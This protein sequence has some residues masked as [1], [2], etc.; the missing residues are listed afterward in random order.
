[1]KQRI[2]SL[3][4]FINEKAKLK[5]KPEFYKEIVDALNKDFG[6]YKFEYFY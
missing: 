5:Y 2:P 4:N 1:M 3:D 6:E